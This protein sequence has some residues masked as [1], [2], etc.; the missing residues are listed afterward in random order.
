MNSNFEQG[1]SMFSLFIKRTVAWDLDW[2]KVLLLDR[3]V[4]GVEL[5]VGLKCPNVHS[6]FKG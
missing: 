1:A 2:L 3:P 6:N 4:L 5:L